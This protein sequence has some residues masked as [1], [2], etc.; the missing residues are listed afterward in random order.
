MSLQGERK[1]RGEGQLI[2]F[3][4]RTPDLEGSGEPQPTDCFFSFFFASE[5]GE[6]LEK[7]GRSPYNASS[8]QYR[9]GGGMK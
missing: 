4:V 8:I 3:F 7:D 2:A 6:I 1:V 5:P 9:R